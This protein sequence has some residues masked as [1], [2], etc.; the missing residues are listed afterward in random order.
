MGVM[1]LGAV[2]ALVLVVGVETEPRDERLY[3]RVTTAGGDVLEGYL[4]WD[5][6]EANWSD[7]LDGLKEIPWEH[8]QEAEEL[9][10]DYAAERRRERSIEAFGV[11]ITWNRDDDED[12]VLV[13]SGVRFAHIESLVVLD[14]RSVRLRLKSGEEV[15]LRAGSSDL[16][17]GFRGLVVDDAREG[18]VDLRWRDVDRVQFLPPPAGTAPPRDTRLYGTLVTRGGVELTGFVA[19]DLD[20]VFT[21]DM[22][23][24]EGV[25]DG[26][27]HEIE[28]GDIAAI[29]HE[30]SRSARVV[31]HDR[32][33]LVLR[34][35]NDVDR[36]N[37]GIEISD[38][39]FGRAIVSWEEFDALTLHGDRAVA[40]GYQDFGTTT[41]IRGVVQTRAGDE[42]A[43]RI[44][45]DNDEEG[46]WE[47][48]DGEMEG[49]D[50]DI[51]IGKILSIVKTG[52]ATVEVTL[53]DGRV[54][55]LE[56][57]NDVDRGN[58]GIFVTSEGGRTVLLHW[59]EFESVI[60]EW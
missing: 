45:W 56:G 5:R 43:G 55:D 26:V 23:D 48:L 41:E 10:P 25:D 9:D 12:P 4:R 8:L 42:W 58:K 38:P 36:D 37:R 44:R 59:S 50:Y 15:V 51:E 39:S 22:L 18:E 49:V 6:N 24:G 16:G 1:K 3:G 30:S 31:L 53:V 2:M 29:E 11:R 7:Y 46:G 32:T 34:G 17:R 54:F 20:E 21:T 27:D 28:F 60:F 47:I 57:S 14:A 33:E 19:W 40:G 13:S 52:S 35:T